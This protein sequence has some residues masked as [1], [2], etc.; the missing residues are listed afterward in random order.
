MEPHADDF[1]AL[2]SGFYEQI[3][4]VAFGGAGEFIWFQSFSRIQHCHGNW[5][6]SV[7]FNALGFRVSA[8]LPA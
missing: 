1:L 8:L 2:L 5:L 3:Q 7:R 6:Y 4:G